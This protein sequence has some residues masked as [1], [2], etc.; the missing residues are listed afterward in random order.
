MTGA[1]IKAIRRAAGMK[2]RELAD[3]LG[4]QGITVWRWENAKS[5]A[6]GPAVKMLE[7]LRV[8]AAGK[9]ED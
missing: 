7:E 3:H 5:Q 4:V 2:Q 8:R 6:H 1:E 9:R